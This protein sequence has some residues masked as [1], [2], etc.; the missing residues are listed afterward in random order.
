[1]Q[2]LLEDFLQHLRHEK[3]QAE[4]TQRTYAALLNH[5]LRWAEA[6]GLTCWDDVQPR[7]LMD[8]V[9][10][11][12]ERNLLDEPKDSKRRLS[13]ESIYLE[14]AALRAFYRFAEQEKLVS[15]N[16]PNSCRCHDD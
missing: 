9:Q 10:S 6:R 8:F 3:G 13:G 11:E 16:P 5:F 1:V 15:S 4:H 2:A 14:I 7:D 12:R